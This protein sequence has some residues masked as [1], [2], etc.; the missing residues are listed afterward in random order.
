[1][2]QTK[3]QERE[4][5]KAP[6]VTQEQLSAFEERMRK[7]ELEEKAEEEKRRLRERPR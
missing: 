7:R 1:M 4:P 5:H 2:Q 3:P 6:E